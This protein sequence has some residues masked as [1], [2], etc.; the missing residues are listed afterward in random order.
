[1]QPARFRH[2]VARREK[3]RPLQFGLRHLAA[4]GVGD[5][6]GIVQRR[7]EV[8]VELGIFRQRFVD[9]LLP[10][11]ETDQ[12]VDPDRQVA[13]EVIREGRR[14]YAQKLLGR[15]VDQFPRGGPCGFE[16]AE[17]HRPVD[18]EVVVVDAIS[19]IQREDPACGRAPSG[20]PSSPSSSS[21]GRRGSSRIE[22]RY[23]SA[24]ASGARRQGQ[25]RAAHRRPSAPSPG[26]ATSPSGERRGAGCPGGASQPGR[27]PA[28]LPGSPA[29][30][31]CPRR[32]P[33]DLTP[34]PT[35]ARAS[36]S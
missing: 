21:A 19:G 4:G 6:L 8:G 25:A 15:D 26:K 14:R 9:D 31:A 16:L 3:Q 1:M 24:C 33:A 13:F 20:R 35:S 2:P 28:P 32:R 29:L 36:G 30:P 23:G 27:C 7:G 11:A 34:G 22:C 18:G 17:E 12:H 10:A 5:T